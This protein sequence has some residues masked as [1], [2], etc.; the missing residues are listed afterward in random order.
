MENWHSDSTKKTMIIIIKTI[1]KILHKYLMNGT[2]KNIVKSSWYVR[3][4]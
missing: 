3:I 4:K 2:K 1:L